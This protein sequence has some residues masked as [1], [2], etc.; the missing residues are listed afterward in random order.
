MT[1]WLRAELRRSEERMARLTLQVYPH[2]GSDAYL[3]LISMTRSSAMWRSQWVSMD[4]T[5]WTKTRC[6]PASSVPPVVG[7]VNAMMCAVLTLLLA[8]RSLRTESRVGAKTPMPPANS[9]AA[10][11]LQTALKV[12]SAV[13]GCIMH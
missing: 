5:N 6:S 2:Y 13:A 8:E 10:R 9:D 1:A 7:C 4:A 12:L 11:K 3:T